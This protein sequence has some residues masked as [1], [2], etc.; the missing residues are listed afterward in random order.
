[1]FWETLW[2]LVLGF[3]LS[4]AVQAFVSQGRDAARARRS[5]ARLGRARVG[6]RDGRRRAART[7]RRRW[8]S[9]CSRRAPTSSSAMVFMFA[10]T[11]LVI[12]L[13]IVL[14][15]LMGWQFAAAEFVG[16]PIMIVLLAVIERVRASRHA[17]RAGAHAACEAACRRRSDA[18]RRS[19]SSR[20]SW[21]REAASR[22]AWSDA[23]G[24]TIADITMLRKELVIGYGVAGFADACMVPT[25]VWNALFLQG[26]G[27]WTSARERA[28]R[29][30]HRA[31]SASSARSA[32]C[33]WRRRS[34][35]AASASAASS[36][37]SSP[38]SSRCR[39]CSST[40]STTAPASRCGCSCGS[41]SSW[42]LAGL[43]GRRALRS[44][45]APSRRPSGRDRRDA[46][47]V[48]LHDV[49]QHRVPRG[50]RG[51]LLA[52]PEPVAC[53]R[54]AAYAIDPICSMQVEKA[55]APAHLVDRGADV[56]FCSDR[57]RE[58]YEAVISS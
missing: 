17:R 40:A 33:R 46:L 12:E 4:G 45:A 28:G 11:N 9:R 16:G 57:C 43:G 38:T 35:R 14:L 55:N 5:P 39:C 52:E 8:R 18:S 54:S 30:V 48:E 23:A 53:R 47:P 7:R 19:S 1:M 44:S 22:A 20:H 29:A 25:H 36:A 41:T 2:A 13:G 49:P 3:G 31:A 21:R 34:G 51:H 42:S 37:S 32:T 24:Y 58:R 50:V 26:H 10:S 56:C 27:F 6:L 15:V